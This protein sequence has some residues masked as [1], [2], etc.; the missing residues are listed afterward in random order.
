MDQVTEFFRSSLSAALDIWAAGGWAMYVIAIIALVMFGMGLRIWLNLRATGVSAVPEEDWRTWIDRPG[1]RTGRVG[2]MLDFVISRGDSLQAT[3]DHFDQLKATETAPFRRD[4]RLMKVCVSTA[5]LVGLLG[6]VTG[7]LATF[8]ALASGSGGT[9][10]M[11]QIASGISEAL[12]TTETGLV[13]ALPGVFFQ[14]QLMRG[15]DRYKA[16]LAHLETV[17]VQALHRRRRRNEEHRQQQAVLE[18]LATRFVERGTGEVTDLGAGA[19]L[20]HSGPADPDSAVFGIGSAYGRGPVSE[21][22]HDEA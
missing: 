19:S 9:K 8:D 13:I 20:R 2:R 11:T 18:R 16:F 1:E 17:V 15:F 10:T 12:I 3:L 22:Q 4:L 5:P 7:M 6:T 21:G 14:Y